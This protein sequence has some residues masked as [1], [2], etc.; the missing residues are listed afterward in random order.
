MTGGP[1][2]TSSPRSAGLPPAATKVGGNPGGF[3]RTNDLFGW[4]SYEAPASFLGNQSAAYGGTLSLDERVRSA[5]PAAVYPMVVLSDGTV[6]L[7]FRTSAPAAG[8]GWTSFSIPLLASAGWEVADGSGNAG[9]AATE[10]QLQGVLSNLLF[11]KLDADWHTETFSDPL[12]DQVDLDNVI[13]DS[14]LDAQTVP[15]PSSLLLLGGGLA[16]AHRLRRR[17]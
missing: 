4:N 7:Q 15:E 13:L 17:R 10:A 11:L 1:S 16:L 8:S 6:L 5:D 2:V 9:P 14:P 3:I 12:T